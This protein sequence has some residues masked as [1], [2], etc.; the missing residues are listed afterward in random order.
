MKKMI[1][2]FLAVVI[3]TATG[4]AGGRLPFPPADFVE[5]EK[6]KG[7][8]Y[9]ADVLNTQ[10]ENLASALI[11]EHDYKVCDSQSTAKS[12]STGKAMQ[13]CA[14][15]ENPT[16][17]NTD[18]D[19]K[20][21]RATS[22]VTYDVKTLTFWRK[23]R[24][25]KNT[26]GIV[27]GDVEDSYNTID[28][29]NVCYDCIRPGSTFTTHYTNACDM[30]RNNYPYDEIR[31][32]R[33]IRQNSVVADTKTGVILVIG[34]DIFSWKRLDTLINVEMFIAGKKLLAELQ[35]NPT[36]DTIKRIVESAPDPWIHL[37]TDGDARKQIYV[38]KVSS[39]DK[40]YL[41][42]QIKHGNDANT[43][44]INIV[45]RYREGKMLDLLKKDT[46]ENKDLEEKDS[47]NRKSLDF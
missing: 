29:S 11:T 2:V 18:V 41:A 42:Q 44:L 9:K 36:S 23:I 30:C 28:P 7:F 47:G 40:Q 34:R 8:G 35:S 3:M 39:D 38:V 46:V 13:Y 16:T 10:G 21:H 19:L 5:T 27:F 22:G 6:P 20:Q 37:E 33:K 25:A 1:S 31:S 32:W 4:C 26:D 17:I 15:T 14:H 45:K 24:T 12:V 43:V